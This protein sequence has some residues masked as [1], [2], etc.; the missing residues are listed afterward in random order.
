MQTELVRRP[1]ER[2]IL[3]ACTCRRARAHAHKPTGKSFSSTLSHHASPEGLS[4]RCNA[5]Q[6]SGARVCVERD[7]FPPP[8]SMTIPIPPPLTQLTPPDPGQSLELLLCTRPSIGSP[9]PNPTQHLTQ[10]KTSPHAHD[11]AHHHPI[12]TR[13]SP[14]LP[15]SSPCHHTCNMHP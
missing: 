7:S 5:T 12:L 10:C 11:P 2:E 8:P 3:W 4:D 13:P 15:K 14:N 6:N 1:W 9:Y